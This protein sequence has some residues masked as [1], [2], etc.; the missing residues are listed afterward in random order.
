MWDD[1][2]DWQYHQDS[3]DAAANDGALAL[4]AIISAIAM[5]ALLALLMG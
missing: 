5:A 4:V 1:D 3:R 2:I